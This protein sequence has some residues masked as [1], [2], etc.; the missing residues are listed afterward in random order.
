MSELELGEYLRKHGILKEDLTNWRVT[1]EAANDKA[2]AAAIQYR[3]E[4]ATERAKSKDLER[5]L[6]RKEIALA[7]TAALLVL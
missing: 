4:L 2:A 6:R 5:E 7:V 1:C 3:C